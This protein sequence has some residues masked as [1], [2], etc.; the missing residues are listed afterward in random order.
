MRRRILPGGGANSFVRLRSPRPFVIP[1]AE[2]DSRG[3]RA[4]PDEC[5]FPPIL[6]DCGGV[7]DPGQKRLP[8]AD[9]A[10]IGSG[11][12]GGS[13]KCG[14]L[15]GKEYLAS[16]DMTLCD[17]VG[18]LG[19]ELPA[20]GVEDLEFEFEF[21]ANDDADEDGIGGIV[22]D[23]WIIGAAA[24]AGGD[25]D[26]A[27]DDGGGFIVA[28]GAVAIVVLFPSPSRPLR[29]AA[30]HSAASACLHSRSPS[31]ESRRF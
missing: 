31:I 25:G 1:T 30:L 3:G 22:D 24:G 5:R 15:I 10:K 28:L 18:N 7:V 6:E 27:G 4:D 20:C 21:P 11:V 17:G 2:A 26:R 16:G 23:D 9:A 29:R 13:S 19:E 12:C 8:L 14:G